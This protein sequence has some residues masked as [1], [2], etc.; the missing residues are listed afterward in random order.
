MPRIIVN[1]STGEA[2]VEARSAREDA[3]AIAR[4]AQE[5]AKQSADSAKADAQTRRNA[6]LTALAD[7]IDADPTILD[8]IK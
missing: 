3:E 5:A 2:V 7:K 4:A 6:Y 8:R 1:V